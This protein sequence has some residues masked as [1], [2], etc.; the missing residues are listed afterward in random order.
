[1]S[2]VFDT[3][4]G[5]SCVNC[6]YKTSH[7]CGGCIATEGNPFHGKCEVAECAKSRGK[8]FCGECESF[9]CD[10]LNKYSFD[11]EHGD[12]G[13]RI[14]NCKKIKSQLVSE[15]RLGTNP[16]SYCGHHCDY[17]F[18]GQWCGG[19]RSDY[20]CCSFA[21]VF[22]DNQCPNVKCAK[23]KNLVGCYACEDL[24]DCH[25]GYYGKENEYIAKA[26]ALFIKKHGEDLY[27]KTL[28]SAV[29]K[30]LNY[31]KSFDETGSVQAAL[32]LLE[33]YM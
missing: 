2:V 16:V 33:S 5:L 7:G 8:R 28:K 30:G 21:G 3:Y 22:A 4:C 19:C 29:G 24:L 9:P 23:D 13:E 17:C 11:S 18:L 15:A 1:M 12:N 27:S 10:I 20:N 26:T 14:E 25:K 32:D 31:P 6:E